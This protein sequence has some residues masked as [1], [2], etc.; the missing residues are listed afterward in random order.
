MDTKR[1][2]WLSDADQHGNWFVLA[3][4][5]ISSNEDVAAICAT[6]GYG[7]KEA[8]LLAAAPDLQ[9]ALSDLLAECVKAGFDHKS[10]YGW[11]DALQGAEEAL[12]AAGARP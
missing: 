1:Q 3:S 8:R 6:N 9:R 5:P 7:E 4:T 11:P 2:K 12:A 10:G